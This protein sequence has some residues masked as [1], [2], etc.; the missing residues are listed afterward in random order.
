MQLCPIVFDVDGTFCFNSTT[1]TPE[2]TRELEQL[3]Q[4]RDIIF[5]GY[6]H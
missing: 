1:I 2:I 6:V 3:S 5:A 4:R